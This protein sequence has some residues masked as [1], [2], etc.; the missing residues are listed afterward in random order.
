M[1]ALVQANIIADKFN[2]VLFLISGINNLAKN[3]NVAMIRDKIPIINK[4]LNVV[5]RLIT[6]TLA[7]K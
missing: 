3:N 6:K 4:R 7:I 5:S 1:V 2:T